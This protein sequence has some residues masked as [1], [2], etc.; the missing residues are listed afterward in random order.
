MRARSG[1]T[2]LVATALVLAVFAVYAQSVKYQF[3]DLDDSEYVYDNVIVTRGITLRGIA[4]AFAPSSYAHWHPL[5]W[6]SHMA[7]IQMFGLNAGGHHLTSVV[8]HAANAALL[9]YVL[10]G[11]TGTLWRSALVAALFALHPLHVESVAWV[12]ERKDVLSTFFWLVTMGA[13]GR[14][15]RRGGVGRYMWIVAAFILGLMSKA[16]LVTLPLVLLLLD[17]WP[18]AR[19]ADPTDP[20]G[21]PFMRARLAA[22]VGEKLPLFA[23]AVVFSVITYLAQRSW[24][25]TAPL[26]SFPLGE[27]LANALVS[28]AAYLAKTIIPIRLAVFYPH[29]ASIGEPIPLARVVVAAGVL[30]GLSFLAV[31]QWKRRPWLTVGWLWYLITLLPVIGIVQIGSQALADRYSYVP[32]IGIFLMLVWTIP[33]TVE[34]SRPLTLATGVVCA[35]VLGALSVL[36]TIQV[37]YWRDGVT[38]YTHAIAVTEKNWL[39]WNNLGVQRLNVGQ[40]DAALD[41]SAHAVQIKPD[42]AEGWYNAGVALGRLGRYPE[43]IAAYR[44]SLYLEP[45]NADGWANLGLIEHAMRDYQSAI[46]AYRS[47]LRLRGSDTVVL[48]NLALA[49]AA[50]GDFSNAAMTVEQLRVLDPR[51]SEALRAQLA[52]TI[53]A[54]PRAR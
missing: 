3:V 13:Y 26:E 32:L 22:L 31:T 10:L 45:A 46:V 27:R 39:A 40:F 35:G 42:Y 50:Q 36:A 18:L 20:R 11:L 54:M 24:G 30:A 21:T 19:F 53:R 23:L 14:F 6:L 41:C 33:E 9:F 38:L 43:A 49:Y 44:Q 7:D 4:W 8:L 12:S 28:Y 5:T 52:E 16:M 15:A 47:A 25:A 29:P 17:Y 48:E 37:G 1:W 34:S 51:K 2:T